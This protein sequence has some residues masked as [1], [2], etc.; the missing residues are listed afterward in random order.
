VL[1]FVKEIN[2]VKENVKKI[3]VSDFPNGVREG[4]FRGYVGVALN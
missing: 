4:K 3:A 2:I 1:W